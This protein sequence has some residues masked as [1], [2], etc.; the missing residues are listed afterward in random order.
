MPNSL[1]A[2]DTLSDLGRKTNSLSH[3]PTSQSRY[4]WIIHG[5]GR[6]YKISQHRPLAQC[7]NLENTFGCFTI[8]SYKI[9]D[10]IFNCLQDLLELSQSRHLNSQSTRHN[11]LIKDHIC[12]C[13]LQVTNSAKTNQ[14][15]H[16][17]C[18]QSQAQ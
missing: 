7:M 11:W 15:T 12:T 9:R 18:Q 14:T 8:V 3:L 16:Q 13:S 5:P 4:T 17:G 1:I 10:M 6:S 2:S